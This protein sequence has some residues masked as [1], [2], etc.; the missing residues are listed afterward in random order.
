MTKQDGYILEQQEYP[1]RGK[2]VANIIG[3]MERDEEGWRW[4][5]LHKKEEQE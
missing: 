1:E 5:E 3:K 2:R 4:Y